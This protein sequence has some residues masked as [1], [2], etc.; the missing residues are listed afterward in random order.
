MC[1]YLVSSFLENKVKNSPNSAS[2]SNDNEAMRLINSPLTTCRVFTHHSTVNSFP[3][4]AMLYE[5]TVWELDVNLRKKKWMHLQ[6]Q[7]QQ[8][9]PWKVP[10][11][12][13]PNSPVAIIPRM[14]I[15]PQRY[16]PTHY[17]C[18]ESGV[19]FNTVPIYAGFCLFW[20]WS[21]RV[22][23][24]TA[25]ATWHWAAGCGN[26]K[27]PY[28]QRQHRWW[29]W[30]KTHDLDGGSVAHIHTQMV[31]GRGLPVCEFG[32]FGCHSTHNLNLR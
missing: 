27:V 12:M 13:Y 6:H 30:S 8:Q 9:L 19:N 2:A 26:Y 22:L 32:D 4:H 5:A 16:R 21:S 28:Q 18:T 23:S 20:D 17:S 11:F 3:I 10:A 24:D 25:T 31:P 29:W 14:G 1:S 15:R 7:Q